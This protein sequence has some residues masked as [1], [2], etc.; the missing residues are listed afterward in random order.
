M[1]KYMKCK[2][3]QEYKKIKYTK[4]KWKERNR[5]IV[6]E[7]LDYSDQNKFSVAKELFRKI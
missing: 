4:E 1:L 2:K 3:M 7:T 6:T 5:G